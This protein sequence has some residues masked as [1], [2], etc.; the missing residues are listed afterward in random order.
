MARAEMLKR[1]VDRL[2]LSLH[3]R[4]SLRLSDTRIPVNVWVYGCTEGRDV[5]KGGREG[6]WEKI[7]CCGD[8][9]NCIIYL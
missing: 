8:R 2:S 1:C 3:A 4:Q 6:G 9:I 5:S 7:R